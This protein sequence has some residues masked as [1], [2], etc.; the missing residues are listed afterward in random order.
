MSRDRESESE[1]ERLPR[2]RDR[3]RESERHE[4]VSESEREMRACPR[5]CVW[6]GAASTA[7]CERAP[8]WTCGGFSARR[9]LRA[10]CLNF[11]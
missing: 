10:A 9:N 8:G 2:D 7:A 6:G 5:V 4:T 3:E 11:N 1:S